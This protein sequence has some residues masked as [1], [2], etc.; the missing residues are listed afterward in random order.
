MFW[1]SASVAVVSAPYLTIRPNEGNLTGGGRLNFV[2]W[3]LSDFSLM[4]LTSTGV[5]SVGVW[6]SLKKAR[7]KYPHRSGVLQ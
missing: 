2:P 7:A 4:A 1:V 3:M 6:C 5:G